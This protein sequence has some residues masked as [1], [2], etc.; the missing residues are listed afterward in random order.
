MRK[1]IVLILAFLV[2]ASLCSDA[3]ARAK[4]EKT[5]KRSS[6]SQSEDN[7][8]YTKTPG[9]LDALIAFANA[10]KELVAAGKQE[11]ENYQKALGAINDQKI[12]AG[13]TADDVMEMIGEP[14][15]TYNEADKIVWVYKPAKATYFSKDKIYFVFTADGAFVEY[16]R[17]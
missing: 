17:P 8:K 15:I 16:K 5:K 10:Q 13:M 6:S 2:S 1:I 7:I 9:S 4:D 3:F 12:S 14:V 11:T